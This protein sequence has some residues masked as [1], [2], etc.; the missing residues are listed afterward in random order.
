MFFIE[1][2][3]ILIEV[4]NLFQEWPGESSIDIV[5]ANQDTTNKQLLYIMQYNIVIGPRFFE[6]KEFKN[7]FGTNLEVSHWLRVL[8]F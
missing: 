2:G 7:D 8:F 4:K 5:T 3:E 1:P 6:K